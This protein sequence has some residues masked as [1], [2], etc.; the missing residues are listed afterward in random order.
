VVSREDLIGR[1]WADG[2]HVDYDRGLNAAVTRLR[3]ALA[4]S[5][6]RPRYV[7]TVARRGYR[8]IAP[9]DGAVEQETASATREP[10]TPRSQ[11]GRRFLWIFAGCLVMGTVALLWLLLQRE[12]APAPHVVPLTSYPGVETQPSFSPDGSQVAFSWNGEAQS[13]FDIYAQTVGSGAPLRLTTNGAVDRS[14]AW[15]PDGRVIAFVREGQG[16]FHVPPTGGAERIVIASNVVR[17]Q[18]SWSADSRQIVFAADA[19]GLVGGG[20]FA[21]SAEGGNPRRLIAP[22][23]TTPVRD[24]AISPDGRWLAFVGC[25]GG[26]RC[27]LSVAEVDR[28]VKLTTAPRTLTSMGSNLSSLAWTVGSDA[29]LFSQ[30]TDWGYPGQRLWMIARYPGASAQVIGF[31]AARSAFPA[32]SR[33]GSRLAYSMR[34]G[35]AD[36]WRAENGALSRTPMSSTQMDMSAVFAPDGRRVVFASARSGNPEIWVADADGANSVRLTFSKTSGSPM[37][38]PDGKLI[39]YDTQTRDGNWDIH[40][41]NAAGGQST[42]VVQHPSLDAAPSFSRDGKSIYFASDRRGKVDVYRV[43]VTGGA[44]ERLT[45]GGGGAALESAD[46]RSVYFLDSGGN[47]GQGCH[48]LFELQM[49]GGTPRKLADAVCSRAFAVTQRGIYYVTGRLHGGPVTVELLEPA[50]G[51]VRTIASSNNRF[52]VAQGLTVSPDGRVLLLAGSEQ[53]GADLYLAENFR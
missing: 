30:G 35:D 13:N 50:S 14:P 5:A 20:I 46:G 40:V 29:I 51:R 27:D 47:L 24:P 34:V 23:L 39:V 37:W 19:M 49:S 25:R 17:G 8:F 43:A 33:A 18:V 53:S 22:E 38:S 12:A 4:D 9:I 6:E 21:V 1:L 45:D 52:Y 31:A 2:T 32:V 16:I 15:S 26:N 28:Q 11:T 10:A 44:P 3:Q 36:L 42:P 41:I 48:P 7:E